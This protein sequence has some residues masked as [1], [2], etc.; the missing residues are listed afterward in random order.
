VHKLLVVDERDGSEAADHSIRSL[1]SRGRLTTLAPKKD[2]VTGEIATQTIEVEGPS[3]YMESSARDEAELDLQN[4]TRCFLEHLDESAGQTERIQVAVRRQA[5]RAAGGLGKRERAA[6]VE[7]WRNAQRLLE[8]LAVEI[9]FAEEIRFP[10]RTVRSRR[11]HERFLGLVM[12]SAFVHQRQR[13]RREGAG[14]DGRAIVAAS[15]DDYAIAYELG[16]ESIRLAQVDVGKA[17]LDLLAVIFERVGEA[18]GRL[19]IERHEVAF[20]CGEL[21]R[22]S[23]RPRAT[24]GRQLRELVRQEQV[25]VASGGRGRLL[26]YR[27]NGELAV[28]P[29]EH[30]ERLLTPEE[31]AARIAARAA[32]AEGSSSSSSSEA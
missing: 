26:R 9:P 20:S 15:V 12:A 11:D 14:P 1:Q 22:W 30:E 8:P 17:A 25:L 13:A 29:P 19:G 7:R 5:A 18:A 4:L 3:A 28:L 6:L 16:R 31:L 27:L 32:A 2:P 23:G 21:C 24:V 10:V